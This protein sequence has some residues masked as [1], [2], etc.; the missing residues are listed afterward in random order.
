VT[1]SVKPLFEE[2]EAVRLLLADEVPDDVEAVSVSVVEDIAG[3]MTDATTKSPITMTTV[4][5]K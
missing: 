3:H 5:A 1:S 4:T 2:A